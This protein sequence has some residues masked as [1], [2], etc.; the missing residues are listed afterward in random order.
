MSTRTTHAAAAIL[1]PLALAMAGA[2]AAAQNDPT[3]EIVKLQRQFAGNQKV[4]PSG[5]KGQCFVGTFTPS[6]D[7]K[8]LSKSLAFAAPSKVVARFSVG[9]GNPRVPDTNKMVNRGFSFRIDDGGRGQT[10]FVM[11]NAPI[12]FVKS[13]EQ[14][15]G[16]LQ[17]R[18]PGPDG[19]PDAEKIRRFTE[20]NPETTAQARF[21][22]SRPL[23][24]SWVGVPYWGVHNYTLT[25]AQGAKQ[26]IKL[27]MEPEGG[28]VGLTDEQAKDKPADF[29]IDDMRG[30]LNSRAPTGFNMVAFLGGRPGDQ[31]NDAT[32]TWVDE[33]KRQRVVLGRLVITQ[34]EKN[35]TCDGAIFDP[36]NLADGLAGPTDE[37]L[38]MQRQPAYAISIA[39]RL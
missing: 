7:A 25:N 34:I 6:A 39:E 21:L 11:I 17:A 3:P 28:E 22:A 26:L 4:R 16:F 13:P 36:T 32:K 35:E 30:R 23:P 37:P 12:N 8:R 33:E 29:L 10:E 18:V 9:G 19:R 15:L 27:K 24:A 31:V 20:A 2:P 38:F 1:V 5:A 14:M